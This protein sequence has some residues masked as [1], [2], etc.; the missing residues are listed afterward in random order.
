MPHAFGVPEAGSKPAKG[1]WGFAFGKVLGLRHPDLTVDG[2]K[3]ITTS[4][5]VLKLGRTVT[6]KVPIFDD[7]DGDSGPVTVTAFLVTPEG[8]GRTEL[9]T[10]HPGVL[11]SG[12]TKTVAIRG[13]VKASLHPGRWNLEI[14]LTPRRGEYSTANN[15]ARASVAVAPVAG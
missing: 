7:G 10:A 14:E 2:G 4:R 8:K 13:R 15:S 1:T 6:V 5:A 3:L 11:A 9:G 12:Q